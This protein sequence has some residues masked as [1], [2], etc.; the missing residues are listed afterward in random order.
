MQAIWW[1]HGYSI[2]SIFLKSKNVEQE[3]GKLQNFDYFDNEKSILSEIKNILY[4]FLMKYK[5]S[6]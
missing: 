6:W 4:N 3:R 5:K 2:F 1:D